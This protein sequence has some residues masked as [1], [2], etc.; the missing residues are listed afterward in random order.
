MLNQQ[1]A[2]VI[3]NA[4]SNLI[5]SEVLKSTSYTGLQSI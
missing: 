1:A 3:S 5:F 4:F 2:A